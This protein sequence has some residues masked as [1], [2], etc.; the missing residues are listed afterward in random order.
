MDEEEQAR[1]RKEWESSGKN[2]LRVKRGVLYKYARDVAVSAALL[3]MF[4][5]RSVLTH[6]S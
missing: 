6:G 3:G 5:A 2:Q 4:S 1:R